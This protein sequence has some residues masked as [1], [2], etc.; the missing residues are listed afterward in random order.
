MGVILQGVMKW[1][2]DTSELYVER[3]SCGVSM[4]LNEQNGICKRCH[5]RNSTKKRLSVVQVA[6]HVKAHV[7]RLRIIE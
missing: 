4:L 5:L 6:A 3:S 2:S 1:S 7:E